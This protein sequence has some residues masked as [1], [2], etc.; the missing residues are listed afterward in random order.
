MKMPAKKYKTKSI[1]VGRKKR[2]NPND[3]NRPCFVAL[4]DVN[5]PH[6]QSDGP[7]EILEFESIHRIIITGLDINYLLEG[8][9][10][11]INDLEEVQV[12]VDGHHVMITGKQKKSSKK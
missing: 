6:K 8:N 9:D 11:A 1:I 3:D 2:L 12:E 10:L 7:K 5:N 4:F